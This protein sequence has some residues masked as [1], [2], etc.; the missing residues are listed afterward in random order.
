MAYD[1]SSSERDGLMNPLRDTVET[2]RRVDSLELLTQRWA[3]LPQLSQELSLS[4]HWLATAAAVLYEPGTLRLIELIRAG[5]VAALAP[6]AVARSADVERIELAGAATL[7]EPCGF[8][9]RDADA[10]AELCLAVIEAGRPV[11]LQRIAMDDPLLPAFKTAARGRGQLLQFE[12]AGSPFVPITTDWQKYLQTLSSRRRQ[13]FRRARRGLEKL[14]EVT[15]EV[16]SPSAATVAAG[17]AA[18]MQVEA[19]SWKGRNGTALLTN[20]RLGEFFRLLAQRLAG[21][22]QLRLCFLRLDGVP[23]AMQIAAVYAERWWVLKIGYD[24]RWAEHSPGI[25]L[26]WEVLRQAFDRRLKSFEML[27]SAEPWLTI[28]AREQRA[29]RTVAFYPYNIRGTVALGADI[30]KALAKRLA[31]Q[32]GRGAGGGS[33][34][35]SDASDV[36]H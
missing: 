34:R 35:N 30:M 33:D 17:L 25:Q 22:G 32:P 10:L 20:P 36:S 2:L 21:Q 29:Y 31:R 15:F 1:V 23:V 6:L 7:Y 24:Q 5:E 27:G 14:G 16:Q 28:W 8:G 3:G 11:V 13:D 26:M 9:Y 18:A 12:A 4:P 19:A